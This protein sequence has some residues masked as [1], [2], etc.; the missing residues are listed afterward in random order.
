[1]K[2]EKVVEMLD[3]EFSVIKTKEDLVAWAVTDLNKP[4]IFPDFLNKTT[5]LMLK[6][7]EIIDKIYTVV[8]ITDQI[9]K[10]LAKQNSPC[11]VF[12]HHNFDYYEDSR[13]L[14]AIS[15]ENI[16]K[17]NDMGHSIFV[18]HASLDVHKE[19]GTSIS[20]AE[21]CDI[22]RDE[23]FY[24]YFGSPAALIG[25]IDR[26]PYEEFTYKVQQ[27]LQ[28]PHLTC[29]KY[30]DY[31]HKIA[32]AAGGG[33]LPDMLQQVYNYGCDTLLTGTIE[34]RWENPVIQK[35]NREFHELNDTLKINLIGGTHFGTER[36]AMIKVVKFFDRIGIPAEYC[37]DQ[38]LLTIE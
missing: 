9:I 30:H 19:F 2:L 4:L 14:Q 7:S 8:F 20:L 25:H 15:S 36:P 35:S 28:R 23:L 1:M 22:T 11:L 6:S 18:A 24:D 5:G 26:T 21:L 29:K 16:Q 34:H 37:E 3:E 12:T 10:K 38:E 27:D 32:V 13:G 33:D 17:L 31:V